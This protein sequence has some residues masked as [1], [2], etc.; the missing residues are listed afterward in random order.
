MQRGYLHL[1]AALVVLA[2]LGAT[3]LWLGLGAGGGSSPPALPAAS[4]DKPAATTPKRRPATLSIAR[5]GHPVVWLK[6]GHRAT[7]RTRPGGGRVVARVGDHTQFGDR[8]AFAVLAQRGRWAG[9]PTTM[10]PNGKLAWIRLDPRDLRSGATPY[11]IV[12]DLSAYRAR[13][14]RGRRVVRSF[15]VTIGAPGSETPS[16]RFAVTDEFRGTLDRAAYGCCALALSATQPHVPS[17]WLGGNIIAIHGT[18]GPLGVAA[19]HGCVRAAD[20]D[21]RAVENAVP[22]GTPVIIRP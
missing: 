22:L 2:A 5:R 17:G 7:L 14:L 21:V 20:A 9:V 1:A 18:S 13:L 19:S 12:V 8:T 4:G 6:L 11:E 3:V 10:L 16:G 15:P